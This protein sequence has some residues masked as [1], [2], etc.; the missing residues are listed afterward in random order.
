MLPDR[1]PEFAPAVQRIYALMRDGDWHTA[2][3]IRAA[4]GEDGRP[5]T[6]GL[7][8]MRQL[9]KRFIVVSLSIS[10]KYWMY[11][12][13]E[14]TADPDVAAGEQAG[15]TLTSMIADGLVEY[16]L[17][18]ES[19]STAHANHTPDYTYEHFEF[20]REARFLDE[21]MPQ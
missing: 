15:K 14:R 18:D 4:A 2:H 21:D 6:E 1:V 7:R 12:L 9:R 20:G 19:E 8:R 17:L 3:D 16:T 5:S 11:R 13:A 10:R